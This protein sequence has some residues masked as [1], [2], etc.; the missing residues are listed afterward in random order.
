MIQALERE[1]EWDRLGTGPNDPSFGNAG[2]AFGE[3]SAILARY[4]AATSDPR[5]P[6]SLAWHTYNGGPVAETLFRFGHQGVPPPAGRRHVPRRFRRNRAGAACGPGQHRFG[7]RP[8]PLRARACRG[9]RTPPRRP[10]RT[11]SLHMEQLES[12]PQSPGGNRAGRR[13]APPNSG[14]GC[15]GSQTH[16][17][18]RT[19][20]Q[21]PSGRARS[22]VC[23]SCPER[24]A[25][26]HFVV[27][28]H[29]VGP[30]DRGPG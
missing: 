16:R 1:V 11:L 9:R 4:L 6:P 20:R 27:R 22:A 23:P 14:S 30:L 19:D 8:R 3:S 15:D 26:V 25:T 7:A 29:V 12:E 18:K 2:E 28:L 5:I 21:D 24:N 13:F 10:A 17:R